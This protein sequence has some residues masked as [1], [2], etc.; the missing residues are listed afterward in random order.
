MILKKK[1]ET[2]LTLSCKIKALLDQA[3]VSWKQSD[4]LS[5]GDTYYTQPPVEL[6]S[7]APPSHCKPQL[8]QR[9]GPGPWPLPPT[10]PAPAAPA[11]RPGPGAAPTCRAQLRRRLAERPHAARHGRGAV[12][13]GTLTAVGIDAHLCPVGRRRG[14]GAP[15]QRCAPGSADCGQRWQARGSAVAG[16]GRTAPPAAPSR[17]ESSDNRQPLVHRPT[18][19]RSTLS[20]PIVPQYPGSCVTS[21]GSGGPPARHL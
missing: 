13:A 18:G 2:G 17:R 7:S 16:A 4:R 11:R 1:T 3:D 8:P 14:A 15:P 6:S 12:P 10:P 5:F 21:A 19:H 20:H 9:G